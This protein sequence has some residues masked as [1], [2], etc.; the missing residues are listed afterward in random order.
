[1]RLKLSVADL[2]C[3]WKQPTFASFQAPFLGQ[4]KS[5]QKNEEELAGLAICVCVLSMCAEV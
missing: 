4:E 1:M 3:L 5:L 2:L